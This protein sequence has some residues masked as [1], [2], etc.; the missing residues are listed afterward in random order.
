LSARQGY[1][2]FDPTR[3]DLYKFLEA[4][5]T[6]MAQLFP[7]AYI[8]IGGDESEG[9]HWTKN[10]Q[11][12]AFMKARAIK[13]NH[14]LQAYFNQRLSKILQKLG[15]KMI[16]WDEILHPALPKDT[17][18]QS[19]R[20]PKSLAEAARMGFKGIL[21]SGFYIDLIFPAWQHY[22]VDPVAA[23]SNL[24]QE[25][26]K[27]ILGG[28]ATMWG[29]WVSPE[30]I[31]SRIWPRTAA[32]AERLWS[33]RE[34][35][36]VENMYRRLEAISIELEELGLTHEKNRDMMLRRIARSKDI[37]PLKT[38]VSVIEPVKEYRRNRERNATMLS[39]LTRLI[40]A[41][42]PDSEAAR[43]FESLVEG[44]LADP[45]HFHRNQDRIKVVLSEW[46]E[47]RPGLDAIIGKSP[48]LREA[49]QLSRDLAEIGSAGLEAISYLAA[50]VAPPEGWREARMAMLDEAAK[51]KAEVEFAI[52]GPVR[53]LV[54]LAAEMPGLKSIPTSEWKARVMTLTAEKSR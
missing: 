12:Q 17:V 53:K 52:I 7:D 34:V 1:P 9:H 37:G 46:R 40:D 51:P 31:D 18:I 6:E 13:D 39:P 22:R 10:E 33:P 42:R 2:A 50:D 43:R 45:P 35:T 27:H 16:G 8:H 28:E 15:K 23:D 26:L 30:T 48:I 14:A 11:I 54:I 19:W 20:G 5:F 44:L 24:T 41:A 36:D 3:E 38:L 29:E 4:F 47:V 25:E 21:S 32:I 49:E